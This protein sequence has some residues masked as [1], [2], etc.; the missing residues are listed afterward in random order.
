MVVDKGGLIGRIFA[1]WFF[2]LGSLLKVSKVAQI[3][4]L[5]FASVQV[6]HKL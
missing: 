1:C 2:F 4:G 3:L 6:M 5:L